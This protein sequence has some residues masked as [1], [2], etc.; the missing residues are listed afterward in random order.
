L[1]VLPRPKAARR[2]RSVSEQVAS[3]AGGAVLRILHWSSD[4]LGRVYHKAGQ[5][6]I[7]FLAGAIAFNVLI[8]AVPFL[9]LM[10]AVFGFVL[11]VTVEDPEQ[12]AVDY[13]LSFLPAS[14]SVIEFTR[15]IVSDIIA[16][17]T[18]A[19]AFG[20]LLFVWFSTRLIGSLRSVL[21]EVFDLQEDRGIIQGKLFDAVMVAV[22]GSLFLLNT[23]IT[24]ALEAIHTYGVVWLGIADYA[25]VRWFQAVWGQLLAFGFIF[26]MFALMYRYLPARRTP[27][28]IAL[29]AATF[30]A[31]VWEVLKAAFAWYVANVADYTSTYGY[32]A[33]LII[34]VF[35]IY[36][37]AVVFILGGEVGQVYELMRTRRKQREMLE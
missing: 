14:R 27:W 33:T 13:V 24:V 35:W 7:F 15:T 28:R 29:I 8:A 32:L 12:A 31:L 9:L 16:G 34:L 6:D 21:R 5:D 10:I 20:L 1:P 36:Y 23:G 37:S 19:G 22:A 18:Q 30:T 3:A 4:F 17:R 26:L 11:P 2:R 25:E